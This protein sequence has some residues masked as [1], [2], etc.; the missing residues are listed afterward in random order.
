MPPKT[1]LD[2]SETGFNDDLTPVLQGTKCLFSVKK[3]LHKP[4]T[5]C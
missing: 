3:I 1:S 4:N 5:A 2:W